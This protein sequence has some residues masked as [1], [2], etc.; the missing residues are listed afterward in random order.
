MLMFYY[1]LI[2]YFCFVCLILC[3]QIVFCSFPA[4]QSD[5]LPAYLSIPVSPLL[6]F[7]FALLTSILDYPFLRL[8]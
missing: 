4:R 5:D 6:L 2:A 3:C 8:L 7:L 1:P